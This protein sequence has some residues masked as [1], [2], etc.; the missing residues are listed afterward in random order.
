MDNISEILT[1]EI[2][3]EYLFLTHC[4][5]DH[6]EGLPFFAP[7]HHKSFSITMW[8]GHLNN[9]DTKQMVDDYMQEPYFPIGPE[10][11]CADLDYR[12][13]SPGDTLK[14]GSDIEIGTV[15]LNHPNG[16]VGYRVRYGGKSICYVTD[17]E[18]I[19]G[20]PDQKILDLIAGAD[21]MIYDS[22]YTDEEFPKYENWGHSTW[23][24]GVRL[25]EKAGVE[26]LVIFHHDPS[27][28]DAFMDQVNAD[29]QAARPG[30]LVAREGM[31][32]RP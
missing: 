20:K 4:H 17:T 8:S 13:F 12:E 3:I 28:D 21:F 1:P 23:Q 27:H 24:E 15:K 31:V 32:L 6:I 25:A 26:K 9:P 7:L 14:P 16:A 2:G 19:P 11:F 29:A 18:H 10:C 5:Y 30:T 22:S